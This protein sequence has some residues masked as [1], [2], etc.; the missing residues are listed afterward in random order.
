MV[1]LVLCQTSLKFD[2]NQGHVLLVDKGFTVQDL[3]LP[4]MAT[5]QI[6][7]FLGKRV[8][9]GF[10][11]EKVLMNKR[12]AKARIHVECNNE[13][14]KKFRLI[15]KIIPLSLDPMASQLVYVAACLVNFQPR[16]SK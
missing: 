4:K 13:R 1:L 5:I 9:K 12:I 16:L 3:L 10:T 2:L 7:A 15:G 14:L 11:K 8:Y 6:P